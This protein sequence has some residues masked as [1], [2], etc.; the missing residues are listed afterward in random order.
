MSWI[1]ENKF[2]ALLAG[3]TLLGVAVLYFVGSKGSKDYQEAMDEYS[4][5]SSEAA[6]FETVVPYPRASNRDQKQKAVN[7]YRE[8]IESLQKAF[9]KYRSAPGEPLS[10]QDFA[11]RLKA[12]NDE[13]G[14]AFAENN[15]SIPENFFSGFPGYRSALPDAGSTKILGYELESLR[16][17]FLA[18]AE[19]GVSELKNVY[20]DVLPEERKEV[21]QVGPG[22]VA[23]AL[24]LEL[25]FTGSEKSV[26]NFISKVAGTDQRFVVIRVLQID[27]EKQGKPP[28]TTDAQFEKPQAAAAQNAFGGFFSEAA[29]AT[30]SGGDAAAQPAEEATPAT[31]AVPA[32]PADSSRTLQ[33]VLGDE[34]LRVFVRLDI[35]QFLPVKKLP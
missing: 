28:L 29:P 6:Q 12:V 5:S 23:R 20:R 11:S 7:S 1:K 35:L 13:L 16:G 2:L 21:Y 22:D 34:K 30:A 10:P 25:T 8:S 4:A 9:E 27:N 31:P 33:Q 26:R 15:V 32:A 18:L 14:K 17:I 3:G 19:S 24:P